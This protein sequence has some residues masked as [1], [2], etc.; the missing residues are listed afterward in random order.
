MAPGASAAG[1]QNHNRVPDKWEQAHGLSLKANQAD[2]DPDGDDLANRYEWYAQ[3]DPHKKDTNGNGVMDGRDVIGKIKSY[4]F[5]G[6]K[7]GWM[8]RIR[9][10]NGRVLTGTQQTAGGPATIFCNSIQGYGQMPYELDSAERATIEEYDMGWKS[11]LSDRAAGV[12]P[13]A[14]SNM[15]EADP[16]NVSPDDPINADDPEWPNDLFDSNGPAQGSFDKAAGPAYA[17]GY[18]DALTGQPRAIQAPKLYG[19]WTYCERHLKPGVKVAGVAMRLYKH[20]RAP[21]YSEPLFTE[22]DLVTSQALVDEWQGRGE[23]PD[24]I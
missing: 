10:N 15:D 23:N 12:T 22:I 14:Q 11:G 13:G 16:E 17:R 6:T 9:L 4:G 20:H 24:D 21:V 2:R 7:R 1:D 3:T 5:E 8:I 18:D 19:F